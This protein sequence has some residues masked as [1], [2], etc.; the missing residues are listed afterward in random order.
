MKCLQLRRDQLTMSPD[1]GRSG[2]SNQFEDRLLAS[3]EEVGLAEPLKV[4]RTPAG[5]YIVVDGNLRLRA[6]DRLIETDSHAFRTI[7]AYVVDYSKRFE[8]RFQTDIY[9]DLLPSQLAVL[10]EHLAK[11][12]NV[13]K[14]DIARYI[15]ISA[16]TLRNY[17]GVGRL[18]A[19]GGLFAR[20]VELMDVGVIPASNPFA[21]LRLKASGLQLVLEMS[22]SQGQ[23]PDEWIDERIARARRGDIAPFPLRLVED[24]TGC[25]L[26]EFYL[27]DAEVRDQKREMGLRRA[28]AIKANA[29]AATE[30]AVKHLKKVMKRSEDPVLKSAAESLVGYLS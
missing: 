8:V 2:K 18:L 9:Q 5:N 25:L 3:I 22:F 6:I 26:P 14:V 11:T 4:A 17:T 13:K 28:P 27:A 19:R 29:A 24:A 20:L 21:W 30:A 1:M 12:E 16:P 23:N 15:G 10:V 7:P